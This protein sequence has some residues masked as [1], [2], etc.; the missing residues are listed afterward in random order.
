MSDQKI[1]SVGDWLITFLILSIPLVNLIVLIVWA[2]SSSTNVI[3]SNF[4]KATL[5]WILII[6]ALYVMFFGALIGAMIS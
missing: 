3:K 2:A 5:I 1:P 6:I 4:S